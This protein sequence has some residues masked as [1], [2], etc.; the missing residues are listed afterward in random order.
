MPNDYFFELSDNKTIPTYNYF[1]GEKWVTSSSGK[2]FEVTSPIDNQLLGKIQQVEKEEANKIII[3][4]QKTLTS[5]QNTP[6]A[7]KIKIL[8]LAA[9][10][11]RE[12]EDFFTALL[13]REI[14]KPYLEAKEEIVLS[15]DI[16]DYFASMAADLNN[17]QW[18][19]YVF[20]KYDRR[21]KALVQR[22]PL[23]IVLIASSFCC[24]IKMAVSK[25]APALLSG[26][27][28]IFRP[29]KTGSISALYLSQVF[30]LAGL[31]DGLL[32]VIT[33]SR[34]EIDWYLFNHEKI[35]LVVFSGSTG[36]ADYYLSKIKSAKP[37]LFEVSGGSVALV[38]PDANFEQVAA[39]IIKGA[40][41]YSGQHETGYRFVLA[42]APTI[43]KL[44]PL[45][46]QK[47]KQMIK[48][49]DPRNYENNLGPLISTAIA[50]EVEKRIIL[51]KNSGAR[52]VTG[53]KRDGQYLQATILDEV[54]ASME[55][56]EQ[57]TLGPV[58]SLIA[59]E[60]IGEAIAIIN[61]AKYCL[62]TT[63]F[64]SDKYEGTNLAQ[65]IN[66]GNIYINCTPQT[67]AEQ[68]PFFNI[69]PSGI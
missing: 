27:A 21:K 34:E 3:N 19:E 53:G 43:E 35:N 30:K 62:Q 61:Q 40:F 65:K 49:G 7:K 67:E 46:E 38:L 63:I 20:P 60:S 39:E 52:I 4:L 33:G 37:L 51:A 48:M 55:I 10:W 54:K 45:L 8:H 2:T 17:K 58:L 6:L 41:S 15:A 31:P 29:S 28:V 59:V 32:A 18:L 14:G 66:L 12:H 11:L 36:Q 5:W 1:N 13:I 57:E 22:L 56:V 44:A 9:D 26:N 23:G 24:P 16:I 47:S 69:Q 42:F 68:F 64:T 25:I 50:D